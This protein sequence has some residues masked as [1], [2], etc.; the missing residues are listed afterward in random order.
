MAIK[1]D[2]KNPYAYYNRGISYDRMQKYR[3]AVK[4]F[5]EAIKLDK[6]KADFFY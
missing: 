5:T 3:P 6:T 4:D 1:I 2:P